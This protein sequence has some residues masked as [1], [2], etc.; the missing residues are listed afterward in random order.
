MGGREG[1]LAKME[2]RVC[3]SGVD[4][5]CFFV[6]LFLFLFL[7][8]VV[9]WGVGGYSEKRRCWCRMVGTNRS[10]YMR[11]MSGA[12]GGMGNGVRRRKIWQQYVHARDKSSSSKHFF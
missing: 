8:L 7:L 5:V 1:F 6:S 12:C 2:I 4:I 10:F 9:G 11:V 3:R